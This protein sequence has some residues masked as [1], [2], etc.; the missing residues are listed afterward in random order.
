MVGSRCG[1]GTSCTRCRRSAARPAFFSS[2]VPGSAR[3]SPT[4]AE[5]DGAW[6]S[7]RS[8]SRRRRPA[9]GARRRRGDAAACSPTSTTGAARSTLR[10]VALEHLGYYTAA[11]EALLGSL[12]TIAGSTTDAEQSRHAVAYL[13]LLT[14]K[15]KS[16]IERAQLSNVFSSGKFA[17]GQLTTV[18]GLIAVQ[19]Q[20]LG[21]F[22][23]LAPTGGRPLPRARARP[24]PSPRS[25]RASRRRSSWPPRRLR[26]RRRTWFADATARIDALKDVENQLAG[27][28]QT[29]AGEQ[30]A[31]AHRVARAARRRPG[32]PLAVAVFAI[33]LLVVPQHRAR[34]CAGSRGR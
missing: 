34:R 31:A 21:T 5:V 3:S 30:A 23:Q 19:K 13:A 27:E 12:G 9:R 10:R 16:G 8:T 6:P 29:S 22:Q 1:S 14:A 15:E 17:P 25:R 2:R 11:N 26:D 28:L 20:E 4:R 32:S 24:R 33:S 7:W 18:S